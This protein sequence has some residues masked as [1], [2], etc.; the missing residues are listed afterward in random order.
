VDLVEQLP[1]AE[2]GPEDGPAGEEVEL[3]WRGTNGRVF[4]EIASS[5]EDAGIRFNRENLDA[6]LTF[7]NSY[8]ALEIWVPGSELDA[9]KKVLD[10]ALAR[11]AAP[12]A[13]PTAGYAGQNETD[14][15][16][17]QESAAAVED[18]HPEDA[19]AEVWRGEDFE[20]AGFLKSALAGNGIGSYLVDEEGQ[21]LV[22]RVV[23]EEAQRAAPIVRQVV[24]G[25]PPE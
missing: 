12:V 2:T 14:D 9:A 16:E 21:P 6:R 22:L 20:F 3:L 10:D 15:G 7:G 4:S 25:V 18:P 23:P 1:G 17:W 24:E 13:E 8:S 11:I 5:L 19:T